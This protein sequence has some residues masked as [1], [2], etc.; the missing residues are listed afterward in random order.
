MIFAD[1][2]LSKRSVSMSYSIL[3]PWLDRSKPGHTHDHQCETADER[4]ITNKLSLL[5]NNKWRKEWIHEWMIAWINEWMNARM[6]EL[7]HEWIHDYMHEWMNEYMN[8]RANEWM[9]E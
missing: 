8:E 4:V 9:N 7:M 5:K 3:F 2:M 1:S 6:N